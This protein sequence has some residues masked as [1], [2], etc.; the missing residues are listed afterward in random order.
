M[1]KFLGSA[2]VIFFGWLIGVLISKKDKF[3]I[4]DLEE[5]KRGLG[6]FS[7]EMRC[8]SIPLSDIFDEISQ[9]CNGAVSKLFSDAALFARE[10]KDSDAGELWQR[11]VEK[12]AGNFY[13]GSEEMDC[14]FSF[15]PVLLGHFRSQ[16]E[17]GTENIIDDI[18]TVCM[19][20]RE[21]SSKDERLFR[22]AGLLCGILICVIIF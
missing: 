3:K 2:T 9:R 19:K 12:N 18:E 6:I 11:A 1:M 14:L 22:S 16:Q 17:Q 8:T 7:G 13:F 5:F 15:S 21:K 4:E 20:L 10:K